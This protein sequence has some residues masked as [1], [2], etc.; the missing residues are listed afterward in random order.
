M[1]RG[2]DAGVGSRG[3][4]IRRWVG[5]QTARRAFVA[6]QGLMGALKRPKKSDGCHQHQQADQPARPMRSRHR[7]RCCQLQA[8]PPARCR[9]SPSM[10]DRLHSMELKL[11]ARQKLANLKND[12]L[13]L[14]NIWFHKLRVG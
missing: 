5:R 10:M 14:K 1:G 7:Q 8:A 4:S 9:R 6:L 12:M 2:G 13:V 11:E 3:N